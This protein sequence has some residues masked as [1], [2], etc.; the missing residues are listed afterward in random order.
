MNVS[1]QVAHLPDAF[2]HIR[3]DSGIPRGILPSPSVGLICCT[4]LFQNFFLVAM[5][6]SDLP[7]S[8]PE[9]LPVGNDCLAD[10]VLP[11]ALP[12]AYTY[13][14]PQE[15][16]GRV[17]VGSRVVVPLGKRKYYSDRR[18]HV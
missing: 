9:T 17:S 2:G 10:V 12:G 5:P 4:C 7:C 15:L 11:L 13:A 3:K 16:A 14:L 18:A 8:V 6:H 1:D